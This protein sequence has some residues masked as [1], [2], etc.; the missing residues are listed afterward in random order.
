ME[1]SYDEIYEA[2]ALAGMLAGEAAKPTPMTV[3][4]VNIADEPVG[5]SWYVP[6]G[7][8]GFAWVVIKGN[9]G[10]G[11]WAKKQGL[12]RNNY[13]GGLAIS[14]REF[15]QSVERKEAYA[16]AFASTLKQNGVDA[17]ADSRLD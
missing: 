10:F 14:V 17:Y 8:C 3:T 1:K 6:E 15:N 5:A 11:R 16:Y 12:A 7:A 4:E 9:T 2:A 13:G